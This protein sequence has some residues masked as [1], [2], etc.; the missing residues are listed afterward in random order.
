MAQSYMVGV[1]FSVGLV[2][3]LILS[4]LFTNYAVLTTSRPAAYLAPGARLVG[5]SV[6][7][8]GT[9]LSGPPMTHEQVHSLDKNA[10]DNPIEFPDKH[11][12]KGKSKS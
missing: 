2:A 3:G 6:N 4:L 7:R 11:V 10:P 12:H 8:S 5:G 9:V 1:F